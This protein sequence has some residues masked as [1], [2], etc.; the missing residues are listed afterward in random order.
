[1]SNAVKTAFLLGALSALFLVL[2]EVLGG[3]QGL[4][5]G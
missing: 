1:M 5:L 2:G 4:V 3:S